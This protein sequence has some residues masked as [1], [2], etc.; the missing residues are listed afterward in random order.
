M[1][2]GCPDHLLPRNEGNFAKNSIMESPTSVYTT[3]KAVS[4]TS[5]PSPSDDM[6]FC[7]KYMVY[8]EVDPFEVL[9]KLYSDYFLKIIK[10]FQIYDQIPAV[11]RL[12]EVGLKIAQDDEASTRMCSLA[13]KSATVK[14]CYSYTGLRCNVH[15]LRRTN[16][17]RPVVK[18]T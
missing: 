11:Q 6:Y 8:N 5:A 1:I 14:L 13:F 18:I 16:F 2:H 9:P 10:L 17:L 3:L 7:V 4:T 15:F 12:A